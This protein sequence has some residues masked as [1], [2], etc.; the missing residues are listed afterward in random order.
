MVEILV[1]ALWSLVESS[2]LI[3]IRCFGSVIDVVMVTDFVS[4]KT[5]LV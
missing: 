1:T 2:T 3:G 4:I 5:L